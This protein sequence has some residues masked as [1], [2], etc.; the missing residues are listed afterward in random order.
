MTTRAIA[1]GLVALA[2]LVPP[3]ALAQPGVRLPGAARPALAPSAAVPAA[4]PAAPTQRQADYI[5][6]VVNSEPVTNNEVR[7]R[8]QRVQRQL[9]RAGEAQ[10]PLD[11]LAHEVM[12]Q[13][14]VEK[15]QVQ[16]AR[17]GGITADDLAID[18][19]AQNIARRNEVS[20]AEMYRRL[21][22]DGVSREQ[23][24]EELRRQ[25]LLQR[26]REREV[27]ARVRV[28]EPEI[29]QFL[30]EQ[31]SLAGAAARAEINL[32]HIL[33]AVPE[34][35]S[36]AQ[37]AAAQAR[38]QGVADKARSG[39]DFAALAR[40]FS[41]APGAAGTG[42]A[43][44]LRS[45]DRYPEL[46]VQA[47]APL[48]VG[49]VA[50][51]VRSGAGFHVLK[52]LDKSRAGMPATVVQSHA[53]H[54]L[55]RTGPQLSEAAAAAQLADYRQ[56]VLAGQADFA[57]LAREHSQDGSAKQGG[58]LGWVN[59]GSFVPEFEEAMDALKPGDIGQ[60]LVSRFGVHLIQLLE[61][62]EQRLTPREQRE[63]ARQAVR[64][65]K[66]E[67]AYATW[68][69]EQRARAYVEYRDPPQ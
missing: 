32:A 9:A 38:A 36:E 1:A 20:E 8:V 25:L 65:K 27:D 64:Q 52:L 67:D 63:L 10:P 30:R 15:A 48:A 61:R 6:A 3:G 28:S 40:E 50:G 37:V 39:G 42:G 57:Q 31:T 66:T 2:I 62:R 22:A 19:A 47:A 58:D 45:A 33:I 60:P 34:G 49:G 17:E 68:T 54:I 69:Q 24:R 44:G 46:F 7:A 23:F 59:P 21:A 43:M 14:I 18:Q 5:V 29:D 56:R 4:A 12:E 26:L 53:R 16:L 13:L 41:D 11:V 51:P 35:A 55:L